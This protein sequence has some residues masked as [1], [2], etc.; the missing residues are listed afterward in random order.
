MTKELLDAVTL[1]QACASGSAGPCACA[2]GACR[3]WESFTEVRWP[4]ELVRRIGTLRDPAIDEPTLEELH[5][6]GT[7]Y[8]SPAAPVAV[9]TAT[10]LHASRV[11]GSA[12]EYN[13]ANPR[14]PDLVVCRKDLAPRLLS[15][16]SG[17]LEVP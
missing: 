16:L 1:Q 14:L 5:P 17:H 9:A 2:L 15:A 6:D 11:D 3:N 13:G 8:G 12:L 7:R 10:G 4:V